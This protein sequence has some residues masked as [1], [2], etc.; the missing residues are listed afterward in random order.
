[1][2]PREHLNSL[3]SERILILDGAMGTMIQRFD[4][5]EEDFRGELFADH[6]RSLKGCNDLLVLT[7]PGVIASIHQAYLRAGA[8]IVETCSFN[9]NALSLAEYGLADQA[10][11]IN[12]AAARVAKES[13]ALY[14]TPQKPRFVA[15]VL[16]PTSRTA[17]ISP[18]VN[19]PGARGVTWDELVSCYRENAQGLLDGGADLLMIETVFDTLNAKAAVY[20]IQALLEERRREGL[21]AEVPLMISGTIVDAAGRTLSGQTVEAFHASLSHAGAW[22]YGLNCSLGAEKLRPHSEALSAVCPVLTSVH[23][24]AGLPNQLGEYDE[25]PAA[26]AAALETFLSDGL[27]NLVGGCCGSTPAH[28]AAVAAVAAKYRPRVPPSLPRRT[29]LSGLEPLVIEDNAGGAS[30]VDIGERT[31]VAGS[32]KFLRLIKEGNFEEAVSVAREMV[33]AGAG[34]VDVCMDD[35]LLDAPPSMARFLNV[36][37]SDPEVARVPVMVDSSRWDAIEAGLRCLQGKGIVNSISLKE[38]EAEFLRRASVARSYGAAVVVM[39]FD[40]SGQADV[41]DRK[42][43]V[44]ERSYHLLVNAGFPPEDIIFD[45]NVLAV[46]TGIPEH[47]GYA[48]DYIRACRWIRENCPGSRVS[49]GVSNLSFS[50]RGNDV[51]REAMHAVFLKHASAAGMS[52]GIVNPASLV[53]YDD[54]ESGLRELAEDVV[55]ARRSDAGERLLT[56]A[57]ELKEASESAGAGGVSRPAADAW[58]SLPAEERIL[59]ALLKGIDDYIEQDVLEVRPRFSRTLEVI[60]GPLMKG[61]NEV[62]DRFGSGRMFLPQVIRSARVMKR[63][64]AVLEPYIQAE[65]AADP[66]APESRGKKIVLATVKGDVH[67][68]GKNIVGVVLGCNGYEVT[69]LGV[70]VPAEEILDA[71]IRENADIVGL[72]GLITPSLDEMAHVAKEMERRGFSIPLLI[73]GATTSETHTALRIA[74]GYSGAAVYVKDASR[75]AAVVRSLLSDLDR[76][77]FLE[78]LETDYRAA[79]ERHE[80]MERRVELIPLEEARSNRV[81]VDWARTEIAE[82]RRK[83]LIELPDYPLERLVPYIDWSYFFY[84]WDL[85]RGFE[86]VLEDPEKGETARRLYDDARRLLDRVVSEKLLR[87]DA[88]L[89]IFP[90]ASVG[91]DLVLRDPE[92]AGRPLARFSFPRNQERKRAGGPNPCLSD[93]VAPEGSGREDWLGVFAVT[94]GHGLD[95]LVAEFESKRDDLGALLAK[96]LADRLAEA[97]AEELHERVRRE[98]WGYAPEEHLTP[99]ELFLG[100][101]RG[102][103]PAFGYPACP[104]HGDK[105]VAFEL[106]GAAERCGMSL[107]SSSMMIP[108]ASVCGLYFAHPSSYYFGVGTL[109]ED[110]LADW[111]A[112]KGVDPE[113]A[114]RLSGRS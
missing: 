113:T 109:G 55:L 43:E 66:S 67:D 58:R 63:A 72:S 36:A 70:M 106:L 111:A 51:V 35:A 107:S 39:L 1:M 44:A 65:K 75:A 27:V 25:S 34:I 61:M 114:R 26:M 92:D 62:G 8:D 18:D 50:F 52:M 28:I 96:I 103:R 88:V 76:P 45:P 87:A 102:I 71:A 30:F 90:A 21:D 46:A 86:R 32:R 4:L 40:E 48:Q 81:P 3:A 94:A 31:N 41:Y 2:T 108:A 84:S 73:G 60:E 95:A 74:P 37:L 104:D 23:P 100:K 54:L 9:A 77:R 69:D 110:Q 5:S 16:G 13:A 59:H 83:G 56:A 99:E 80:R 12:V 6:G 38:G 10:Y 42:I 57:L 98:F 11:R 89:G 19:D 53:N 79:V 22:C 105:R 68:I 7:R 14:S 24:N 112:R 85:G 29:I 47:D 82:P 15:G 78:K 97:A 93:F 101:Y 64:V 20:A 49:G 17:S 33:D 91:D